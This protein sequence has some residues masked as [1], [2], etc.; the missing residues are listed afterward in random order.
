VIVSGPVTSI[1]QKQGFKREGRGYSIAR[2]RTLEKE[3]KSKG[4]VVH[5]AGGI[6]A[7]NSLTLPYF[8]QRKSDKQKEW[9]EKE[10]N[11]CHWQE[12]SP[13]KKH[14]G[15]EEIYLGEKFPKGT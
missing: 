1:R 10:Q 11:L 8:F 15:R 2:K 14:L 9:H 3:F 13:Q 12:R 4:R 7:K 5:W 6:P